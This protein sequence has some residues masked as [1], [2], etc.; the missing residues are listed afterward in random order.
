MGLC[1]TLSTKPEFD[2]STVNLILGTKLKAYSEA[3]RMEAME[4][5]IDLPDLAPGPSI[6]IEQAQYRLQR[7]MDVVAAL[8]SATLNFAS[9]TSEANQGC[10]S[11]TLSEDTQQILDDAERAVSVACAAITYQLQRIKAC[12]YSDASCP[13]ETAY[14]AKRRAKWD[15]K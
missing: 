2:A 14:R 7:L 13:I 3:F 1:R 6:T 15:V 4:N 11:E 10:Y 8:P 12:L 9:T 5:D